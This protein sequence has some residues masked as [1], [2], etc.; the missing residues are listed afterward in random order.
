MVQS[1]S[2]DDP[3]PEKWIV[4]CIEPADQPAGMMQELV[5]V[6]PEILQAVMEIITLHGLVAFQFKIDPGPVTC[7][8]HF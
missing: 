6:R 8:L 4:T 1:D 3:D 2:F 5:I 7:F